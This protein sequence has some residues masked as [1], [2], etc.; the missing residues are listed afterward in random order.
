MSKVGKII[1]VEVRDAWNNEANDFTPWLSNNLD[2]LGEVI[3]VELESQGIEVSVGP[4]SADILAKDMHGRTVLIENQLH[5]TDHKHLGQILTYLSGLEAEVVIWIAADFREPH[6]SAVKWLNENTS[7]EFSF[8]A[9]QLRVVRIENSIP[10]PIF[11]VLERP[12]EW[13]R[14][15]KKLAEETTGEYSD[16]GKIRKQF[17]TEY[18]KRYPEDRKLG[19]SINHSSSQWLKNSK[20]SKYV[21]SIYKAK[22][23]VGVFLRGK[24]GV[25]PAEVQE[26]I[27]PY[28]DEFKNLVGNVSHIGDSNHHPSDELFI[29]TTK[30]ENWDEAFDWLHKRANEFL[31]GLSKLSIE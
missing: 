13:D 23:G 5:S 6:L 26:M 27:K 17:W 1:N 11:D 22:E 29:D 4:F 20:N 3:G 21:I 31:E 15:I 8:F 7:D 19:V 12:N 18:L 25:S 10:A 9:I 14:Q 24:R 28:A 30:S 2:A 16:Y